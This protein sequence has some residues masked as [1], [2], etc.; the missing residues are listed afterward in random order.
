MCKKIKDLLLLRKNIQDKEAAEEAKDGKDDLTRRLKQEVLEELPDKMEI[1][2]KA[3]MTPEQQQIYRAALERLRPRINELLE[4]Q[5]VD[6]SR[7]EVLSAITELREI[8]CH[9]SLVM[10]EYRG[11]SGKED[12]L[13]EI[14]PEM[15]AGGRRI[16]LFSQFTS[17]LKLLRTRLE[18]AL[19]EGETYLVLEITAASLTAVS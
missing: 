6:R 12:L 14:L 19:G 9:P 18:E 8:C 15:I 17:M 7:L 5:G 13:L 16:L 3:Q 2:M 4:E 11:G 1:T 10:N